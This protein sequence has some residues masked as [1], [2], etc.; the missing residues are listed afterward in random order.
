MRLISLVSLTTTIAIVSLADSSSKVFR[1]PNFVIFMSDDQ[2]YLMHSLDYLP[3][4]QRRFINEGTQFTH[5]HTTSATCC[6]SRVSFWL[7]QFA[8]NHNVT[9]ENR[10]HG[11]YYK[12]QDSHLDD[13]WLPLWLQQENYKNHY[14]GK[15]ING[16]DA[17]N[18]AAPKGWEHFEPLISPGIYNFTNPIFS[19]NGGPL[20]KHPG[21]YQ[22]DL[23]LE[24]SLARIDDI[25]NSDDPVPPSVIKHLFPDAKVPRDPNFNPL[26]QDKVGWVK[27]LPLLSPLQINAIDEHYRQRLRSLQATDE[28]VEA[29]RNLVDNTYFIYTTDNGYH[30]GHHRMFAGKQTPYD[31]DVRI[32]F[33][34]R[35]PGIAK[36]QIN[37]SPATSSHFAATVLD[38]ANIERP[39]GLD[40]TSLFDPKKTESFAI[41]FWNNNIVEGGSMETHINN[42]YKA[43]R[44]VSKDFNIY[45]S[46]WCTRE[47][48]LYEMNSDPYQLV[49]KYNRT[50]PNFLNRLDALLHVLHDCKGDV[51]QRPWNTLH[52]DGKVKS[53]KDALKPKYDEHYK[54][55]PKFRFLECKVYYDPE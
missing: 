8:H 5:Y 35:G 13:A 34:I 22:T 32:P 10:P 39:D 6:P 7:G 15:F 1:N 29:R 45:Y 31:T 40:A 21:V 27:D 28:L 42:T 23:I 9:D 52:K 12:F 44:L 4:V 19:L 50:D 36:K 3:Y 53:L 54:A 18:T 24:K 26:V 49:N 55:L 14:I 16:L 33:I 38:L 2:D 41:E 51:C 46:A 11:S 25:A 20:E 43:V 17:N 30:L 48:E 47:H 37:D